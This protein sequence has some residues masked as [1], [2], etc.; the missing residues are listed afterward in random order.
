MLVKSLLVAAT[1][2]CFS[3]ALA[4]ERVQICA[5]Y[6]VDYGWSEGYSVEGT[7]YKGSE[8][9]SATSTYNYSAYSTYVAIFWSNTQA[10]IIKMNSPYVTAIGSE[11][12]DQEGRTWR[13]AKTSYCY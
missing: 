9:N 8:L 13:I 5:K 2:F 6:S 1:A 7:I 12:E 4:E 3:F 10:T 11:G